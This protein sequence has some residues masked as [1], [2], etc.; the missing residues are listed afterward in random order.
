MNA[1]RVGESLWDR[2]RLVFVGGL[3][4]SG[5]TLLARCLAEHP[6]ASGFS[7]TGAIEDEGQF[8]Q[9]VYPPAREYGGVG[10]FGFDDRMHLTETDERITDENRRKLFSEWSRHWDLSRWVLIEKS[11]PNILKTRFLQAMFPESRFVIIVRHPVAVSL[12]SRKWAK[13]ASLRSL[14]EHWLRCHRIFVEDREHLHAS[15]VLSYGRFVADPA[16]VIE[17]VCDF[18]G[19]EAHAASVAVRTGVNERYFEEWRRRGRG[20]LSRWSVRRAV[21]D[22]EKEVR[23]FGYSLED[24]GMEEVE[25]CFGLM[26]ER[27]SRSRG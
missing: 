3:H 4:R 16:G 11:P 21:R 25:R 19:V 9:S 12:A 27:S 26:Q 10:R 22:L 13:G 8:L 2:H 7:G 18:A 14:L 20:L 1:E 23:S 17:R 5:T 6:D 24:L 15:L